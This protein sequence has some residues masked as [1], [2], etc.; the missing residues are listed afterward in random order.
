M[1]KKRHENKTR[2][3]ARTCEPAGRDIHAPAI[4]WRGATRHD[5]RARV[6]NLSQDIEFITSRMR[7]D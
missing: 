4:A 7:N 1:K 5:V 3:R 6:V 2:A